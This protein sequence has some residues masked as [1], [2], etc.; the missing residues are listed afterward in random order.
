MR[1]ADLDAVHALEELNRH[2]SRR[3]WLRSLR[4][5]GESNSAV[6]FQFSINAADVDARPITSLQ[7]CLPRPARTR[8]DFAALHRPLFW[9]EP[10]NKLCGVGPSPIQERAWR[11]DSAPNPDN[12]VLLRFGPIGHFRLPDLRARR[13]PAGLRMAKFSSDSNVDSQK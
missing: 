2:Q 8:I 1:H 13:G 3:V 6:G 5:P 11:P 12:S 7:P 4:V 9:A 10:T